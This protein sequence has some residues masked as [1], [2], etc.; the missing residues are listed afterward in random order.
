ML[1]RIAGE[2]APA[3]NLPNAS[4]WRVVDEAVFDANRW[5][6]INARNQR[7]RGVSVASLSDGLELIGQGEVTSI[8]G[9]LRSGFAAVDVDV[10]GL[11]GEAITEAVA[12]W[13]SRHS[14]WHVVRPSGGA[15]GRHHVF[16]AVGVYADA[17]REHLRSLRA[18]FGVSGTRVDLRTSIR[19]LSAPHRRGG[20]PEPYGTARSAFEAL[21]LAGAPASPTAARRPSERPRRRYEA[22][23]ALTPRR[24]RRH[25]PLED[26]WTRFLATGQRPAWHRRN[27]PHVD[28]SR[29][30][31][32]LMCTSAM[33]RAGW[34]WAEAW[35][36]I[37]A[38]HPDAMT[39]AKQDQNRWVAYVW[40]AAVRSD[41]DFNPTPQVSQE[42]LAA[43]QAARE[44][45]RQSAWEL[46]PKARASFLLLAMTVLRRM[47]STS[48]LRVP[49]P[50]RDLVLDT[51]IQCRKTIRAHL[52]RMDGVV[53]VLH[54][55]A[56]D[57]GGAR[58]S[59][60]F[61]FEI[62]SPSGA[63]VSQISPPS[64]HI[65]LRTHLPRALP[66]GAYLTLT[67]LTPIGASL[68]TLC[69]LLQLTPTPTAEP[70][71]ST[72]RTLQGYLQLLQRLGLAHCDAS[73]L[74]TRPPNLP[75]A[76]GPHP[77]FEPVH[78]L[79][80]AERA[81]WRRPASSAW[82]G[83]RRAALEAQTHRHRT[84]WSSLS[85]A[86]RSQRL[87]RLEARTRHQSLSE[88]RALKHSLARR[89]AR[90]GVNEARRHAAWVASWTDAQWQARRQRHLEWWRTLAPPLR[91]VYV[92]AWEEHR[93][94]TGTTAATRE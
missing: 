19:P 76:A 25:V 66:L 46:S 64:F 15:A 70:S 44:R 48:S 1:P 38:S 58:E 41:D 23:T 20:C 89:N 55:E 53:G 3:Q 81:A 24:R 17:L 92:R 40:N 80:Q 75:I 88:Q 54:R 39:H 11:E 7:V 86:E 47:E 50:E 43:T 10:T 90:R 42:I 37:R 49:V 56:L 61:E 82:E 2:I 12:Q 74:W 14:L 16:L 51:G 87:A 8:V 9:R 57:V 79:I 71:P 35:D 13:C 29:S 62:G 18:S 30:T 28:A 5:F 31:W 63:E 73:G 4:T 36:A 84:W 94:L 22:V 91:A 69:T 72:L 83:Q 45:V 85:P 34:S 65:P 78:E 26:K 21:P 6:A 68:T 32:E 59:S 93:D 52:R 60:S 67:H 33:L 77:D 27:D